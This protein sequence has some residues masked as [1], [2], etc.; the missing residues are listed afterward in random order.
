M[1]RHHPNHP[2]HPRNKHRPSNEQDM[3]GDN[4]HP[5]DGKC[6]VAGHHETAPAFRNGLFFAE[7]ETLES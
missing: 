4:R 2:L 6:S 5:R 7:K 3:T 1:G